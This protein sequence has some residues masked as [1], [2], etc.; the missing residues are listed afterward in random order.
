MSQPCVSQ[1]TKNFATLTENTLVWVDKNHGSPN[2]HMK[3]ISYWKKNVQSF[4]EL[5]FYINPNC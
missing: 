3:A 1:E 2:N 4:L 5:V